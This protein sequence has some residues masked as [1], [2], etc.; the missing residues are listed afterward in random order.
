LKTR[1]FKPALQALF[2]LMLIASE[3]S[4]FFQP[5]K[6]DAAPIVEG[7]TVR[8]SLNDAYI[9]ATPATLT[10][11]GW[12]DVTFWTRYY[13]GA[14]DVVYGF[15]GLDNVKA[16]NPEVWE[17]YEHTKTRMID[18]V[19]DGVFTPK[20]VK[21]K[22][23]LTKGSK[24][25]SFG[26]SENLNAYLS[27]VE[28]VDEMGTTK[29]TTIAYESYDANTKTFR[30][31]SNGQVPQEY[32][33]TYVDWNKKSIS[34]VNLD[35]AEAKKWD[36]AQ[37]KTVLK[38]EPQ[39]TRV[40]IDIP[41][42]GKETVT[43]KYNIGI[44]PSGLTL[45]QAKDQGKLW[46]LDPWYSASWLYRKELTVYGS[47]AGVQTN[48][49][50]LIRVYKAD[51]GVD[52]PE[53]LAQYTIGGDTFSVCNNV[54]TDLY[55]A[56]SFTAEATATAKKIWVKLD[57]VLA[58][59]GTITCDIFSVHGA[60]NH[61]NVTIGA[62]TALT[63]SYVSTTADWYEF[64]LGAGVAL[65]S[66]TIYAVVLYN[67]AADATNYPR[68]RRTT[69][70]AY[71]LGASWFSDDG[72]ASYMVIAGQDMLFQVLTTTT[73]TVPLRV[74]T[75]AHCL[76]SFNDLRFTKA[77]GTTLL[78][79]WIENSA[80][81]AADGYADCWV[82]LDTIAQMTSLTEHTHYYLY[83]GNAGASA[84]SSGSS[85]MVQFDN[86][87][88][89][90]AASDLNGQGGWTATAAGVVIST[91]HATSGS[92]SVKIIGS[93]GS[94]TMNKALAATSQ[95]YWVGQ[96][97]WKENAA[98]VYVGS[99]GNGTN[100]ATPYINNTEDIYFTATNG[101]ATDTGLNATADAWNKID[102]YSEIF[103]GSGSFVIRYAN[104]LS[105]TC[106]MYAN[107]GSNGVSTL[108]DITSGAGNDTYIDDWFV[109][110]FAVSQ[111]LWGT[112]GAEAGAPS[113]ALT[114]TAQPD[115]T[116]LE[117]IAGG[118]T[119]I[120]T[121]TND[122]WIAAGAGT[123]DAQR[124]NIINGLTSAG[125]EAHGWNVEVKAILQSNLGSVVR[126]NNTVVTITLPACPLYSVTALETITV[127][128]PSTAIDMAV[129]I[130]AAPTF[131][132]ILVAPTVTTG[133]C[134]GFGTNWAILNGNITS[135]G[136]PLSVTSRGFNYGL[137]GAYGSTSTTSG[138]YSTGTYSQ[139]IT[140]LAP[141]TTYHYRAFAT[142]LGGTGTGVDATFTTSGAVTCHT[143]FEIAT[144]AD[145]DVYGINWIGQSFTTPL[146]MPYT[147]KNVSI[148]VVKVGAP[149]GTVT[150]GIYRATSGVPYGQVLTSGTF[151]M[152]NVPT[153][154]SSWYGCTVTEIS[155]EPNTQ[156][157]LVASLPDGTAAAYL[158]WNNVAAGGYTGGNSNAS[159]N[160]GTDWVADTHD[161][162][163]RICGNPV[164]QIQDVKVF[165]TYRQ[166]NDWLVTVRYINL[167]PPYY[168]TYDVK[169]YFTLQLVDSTATVKAS[170]PVPSW[171]NRV[172]NIYL[173]AATTT[174]LTYGGDYRVRI[175]GTF[176][177]NP[178]VEYSIQATDWMGDDLVNLDSWVITSASVVGTYYS[179]SMTTYIAER[180][181]VL[182]STGAGI[183]SAG[184][185]GLSTVRP[186]IFQTYTIPS[187][188]T[189]GVITQAG[190]L[191][192][193]A[194]QTNIGTE[195]TIMLTRL[196]NI[197]GIGGDII[198]IIFMLIAFFILM[199]LAFPAGNTTAALVL[200][201]PIL[202]A[203]IWFGMDL[204]Y[205]G[206]LAL[207]A[208]FLFIKNFWIDKGN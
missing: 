41:F 190:R 144:T 125:A 10:A 128:V 129:A 25:A 197:V 160:S 97:N 82:E 59:G 39:M 157:A 68:W 154:T 208:A 52:M 53:N 147:V 156:Y 169:K 60:D 35:Y 150:L 152:V 161:M 149:T 196:G 151:S 121:L 31:K 14:V 172:G 79:Y 99:H 67:A 122:T 141:A 26:K 54:G 40:W 131:N 201:L 43:G 166:T 90:V 86:F 47:S 175:Y 69:A 58:P 111:P 184:I 18:G 96:W 36:V 94:N 45:Q 73:G 55:L 205:I 124:T 80:T 6:V 66:G 103:T 114:G 117:V 179:T 165:Q 108:T 113:C 158:Q 65:T 32:K 37:H 183:F 92:N 182:N 126:T 110:K 130:V 5:Y 61:P 174:P 164:L 107:A 49:Q 155:L 168:D 13:D 204:I 50:K 75:E 187:T 194:W 203:A 8:I 181:E 93:A 98:G 115:C 17:E 135:T 180:G 85:T 159:A 42:A 185:A 63:T 119:I 140:G 206:M 83:Y 91:D 38:N 22:K 3:A 127:T 64:D 24:A 46:L 189:P 153:A 145:E 30:Y 102:R 81:C 23:D 193:P 134:T 198:A 100:V 123:F 89:Y 136:Y 62:A 33:E 200:S 104:A 57:K 56:Q 106:Q 29:T 78:D 199:G 9:E 186:A 118:Q 70:G 148:N 76:A 48:Y 12:V 95:A 116:A 120:L 84:V 142:G 51:A 195:G 77:D 20:E 7:N 1:I 178:Y 34:S 88:S 109:A 138:A 27:D 44:K 176:T 87:D 171:G 28:Y 173:S 74:D 105:A 139:L 15:N 207:V 191:G 167:Y 21:S 16:I 2:V 133:L 162:L 188:Y 146:G 132:V 177:G 170:S 137:T 202:G 4:V 11:S 72:G 19:V 71:S 163:F 192:I 112:A 143:V 101:G